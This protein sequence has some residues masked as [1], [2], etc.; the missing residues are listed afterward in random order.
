MYLLLAFCSTVYEL[1][2]SKICTK[3]LLNSLANPYFL[4]DELNS[5]LM[6]DDV[7]LVRCDFVCVECLLKVEVVVM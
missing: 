1:L 5:A 4:I 2:D 3:V 7:N 6:K